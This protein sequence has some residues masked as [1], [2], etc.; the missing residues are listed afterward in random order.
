[1][2]ENKPMRFRRRLGI[3]NL[4]R[5][6]SRKVGPPIIKRAEKTISILLIHV[7]LKSELIKCWFFSFVK[8]LPHFTDDD[9]TY[10]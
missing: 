2:K 9:S 6:Y 3:L 4:A 1:M 5:I 10:Y 8:P 7:F